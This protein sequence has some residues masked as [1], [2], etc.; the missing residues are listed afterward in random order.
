L[1]VILWRLIRRTLKRIVTREE[2]WGN[3]REGMQALFGRDSI[4]LWAFKTYERRR[5]EYPALL[6]QPEHA[7][8]ALVHL[9]LPRETDQ[10]LE[11]IGSRFD[12]HPIS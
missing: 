4:I 8:L 12:P 7:H 1:P 3:N 5:R 6:Q 11:E 9:R 2:L 10:W